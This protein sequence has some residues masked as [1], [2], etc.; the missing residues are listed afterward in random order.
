MHDYWPG[1][2]PDRIRDLA[3]HEW[4][5]LALTCDA[6]IES[7]REQAEKQQRSW[8]RLLQRRR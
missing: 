1:I 2:T 5:A 3:Y 7:R 8:A 6:L 4:A